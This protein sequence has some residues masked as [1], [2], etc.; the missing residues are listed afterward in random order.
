MKALLSTL[1]VDHPQ[2]GMIGG[3]EKVLGKDNVLYVETMRL[4][5]W[6]RPRGTPDDI[7][8]SA[9]KEFRPDWVWLQLQDLGKIS[10]RGIRALREAVPQCIV[11]HW[12]GD[13]WPSVDDYLS[14]VCEVTHATLISSIGQIPMYREAG[15]R[16]VRY[17]Q[18]GLDWDEDVA[19]PDRP[20]PFRVPPVVMCGNW[21]PESFL[22]GTKQREDGIRA[23]L[24]AGIDV[25]VVGNKAPDWHG[26]PEWAPT[27]GTCR[28]K[29]Q[30]QVYRKCQV[31]LNIN[32]WNDL[33]LYYS[34][35]QLI[36]MASGKPLVCHYVPGLEREFK[37]WEHCVWYTNT[38]ELV[39]AV[40]RLLRD[41]ELRTRI[42]TA[43]REEV[44]KNHTWE[45]RVRDLLPYIEQ[46]RSQI[47]GGS[48]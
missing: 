9:T 45:A 32:H 18:V 41:A 21:F 22:P 2:H 24:D 16:E 35:R 19:A 8:I 39:D 38:E 29:E 34:D 42:G 33:E 27:I 48:P 28:V 43:G 26:W 44:V 11:T 31:G 7:L 5:Q 12:M 4:P 17:C 25:G 30:V 23:L 6:P 10:P 14:E 36:A 1:N 46:L 13:C 40:S 20:P 47:H 3:F 15:A 37:N